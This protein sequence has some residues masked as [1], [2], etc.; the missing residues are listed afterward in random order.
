MKTTIMTNEKE[1]LYLHAQK[2]EILW[3][4]S[5]KKT[6]SHHI[7]YQKPTKKSVVAHLKE[8]RQV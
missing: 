1:K 8:K 2:T 5:C 7:R 4:N 6:S 3:K